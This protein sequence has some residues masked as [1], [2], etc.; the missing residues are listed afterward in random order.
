MKWDIAPRI[1]LDI[2]GFEGLNCAGERHMVNIHAVGGRQ[3]NLPSTI[4]SMAISG[5][6][7]VRVILM[8]AGPDVPLDQQTWRCIRLMAKKNFRNKE[9]TPTVRIP[10]LDFY[11]E[12][13]ARR[14]DTELQSSYEQVNSMTESRDWTFGRSGKRPMKGNVAFIRVEPDEP[15]KVAAPEAAEGIAPAGAHEAEA[16]PAEA[17]PVAEAAPMVEAA[18]VV[19]A[20]PSEVK[21]EAPKAE[22]AGAALPVSDSSPGSST[23]ARAPRKKK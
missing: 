22:A 23:T 5:L 16:A 11:D 9:G 21:A 18:P 17:A 15:P 10:D 14:S 4:K 6:P 13:D 3:G 1:R 2:V 7:G 20:A 19:E 8:S 12:P